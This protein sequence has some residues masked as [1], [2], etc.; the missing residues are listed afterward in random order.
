MNASSRYDGVAVTLHWLMAVLLIALWGLGLVLEELPKGDF[1]AQMFGLHKAFGALVLVLV[2]ARL[3]WRLTHSAPALPD[4]MAGLEA[5]L[6][7]LGHLALYALMIVL[8]LSGIV[9]SQAGGREVSMFG[10]VLPTLVQPDH[11]LKEAF[12]EVHEV[13]A[14]IL[15]LVVGG[16][17]LA[18]LRHH[19]MLKDDVLTRM[20]PGGK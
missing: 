9:M 17:L 13:L 11:D 1:R 2:A 6:A 7:R 15:A 3:A 20:L 18:A 19:F 16:H 14:W 5:A 4:S 8:P 12:E 10:L